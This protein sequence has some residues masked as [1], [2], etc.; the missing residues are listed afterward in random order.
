[1]TRFGEKSAN[2]RCRRQTPR[3]GRRHML[4]GHDKF[5]LASACKPVMGLLIISLLLAGAMAGDIYLRSLNQDRAAWQWMHTLNLTEPTLFAA[6]HPQR[7]P[8]SVHGA[9]DLRISAFAILP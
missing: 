6:G 2:A 4:K 1:M 3:D 8:Q 5:T 9:V 7:H